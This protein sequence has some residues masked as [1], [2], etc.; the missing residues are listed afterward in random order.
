MSNFDYKNIDEIVKDDFPKRGVTIS[1][2]DLPALQREMVVP[3]FIP[4]SINS[5]S[6]E[7]DFKVELHVFTKNL[8]YIRSVY[9]IDTYYLLPGEIPKL[10]LQVHKDLQGLGLASSEYRVVYNLI[11]NMVGG[12]NSPY[13]LF[14]SEISDDRTELKLSLADPNSQIGRELLANFVLENVKP[15][16]FL[17]PIVLNFGENKV[18]DVIN[19][20]SDGS[21]TSFF[22]KLYEPLPADLDVY[23]VCWAGV[24][25]M[26]P[27]IDTVQLIDETTQ[28]TIPYISGPNFEVD[29]DYWITT[30]TDYKSWSDI[31][32]E[33][34]QTSEQL[35]NKYISS[36]GAPVELNVDYTDFSNFVYYSNARDRVENFIYKMELIEY[37]RSELATLQAVTG[38]VQ[39]NIVKV[40][41]LKDKV[42]SGFD[43]FEKHL[44][45]NTTGS[46]NYTYQATASIVPYPKYEVDVTSS[47]YHIATKE[48]KFKFYSSGSTEV[49]D[50]VD[51]ILDYADDYDAKNYSSLFRAL[52]DHVKE[53]SEND[54]AIMFVN[55]LGQHFDIMYLYTDH[56]LK[57]NLREEHPKDGL[58][59]DLIYDI[60][61]NMGWTLS[62][63]TSAKDLWEYALGISGSTE[64][65]WTGKTT[66][67]RYLTKSYEERTKEVWRRIL[68][69]LPYIYKTKGT[70]RSIKALLAAYGIPSTLLTI[71]EYGGPDNADLGVKPR[72]V[73][74]KHTY[75]LSY[76]SSFPVPTQTQYVRVPWEPVD[77]VSGYQYPDSI[78]FRWKMQTSDVYDYSIGPVQTLLQKN[79][80]SRVDWFVTVHRTGSNV[81]K[82]DLKFH[83]GDGTTY[84]TASIQ[85]EYLFDEVPLNIM[86]QRSSKNDSTA[87]TQEYTLYLKSAKY[88]RIA[89]DRSASIAVS[90][91]LIPNTQ[92]AWVS[93]GTLYIGSGSNPNTSNILS[94]SIF[95]LRYWTQILDESVFENHVL[96]ARAYN[97]NTPTSSYYDLGAQFKFWQPFDAASTSSLSSTH[98]DQTKSSFQTSQKVATLVGFTSHSFESTTETYNMEVATVGNNTPFSEKVRIDSG[99]LLGPLSIDQTSEVSAFD[100][101][102]VDSNRLMVAFS[103][104]SIINEDI[105]EA[106]GNVAIDDYFGEYSNIEADE[107]PRLKWL[108]REYWKKYP[109]KNDFT[110]YIRLISIFDF[111]IFDQIRQALP[112]RANEIVGIVVE[113]NVLERSKVRVTKGISGESPLQVN[114]DTNEISASIAIPSATIT[115]YTSTLRIGFED[116]DSEY[117]ELNAE[118]DVVT[119]LTGEE[120][121]N[122]ASD[123]EVEV[124][125]F[126]ENTQKT[127]NITGSRTPRP[128]VVSSFRPYVGVV[129][130]SAADTVGSYNL[131]NALITTRISTTL[132][133]VN[134]TVFDSADLDTSFTSTYYRYSVRPDAGSTTD[135]GYGAGW[136]TM[137]NESGKATALFSTIQNYRGDTYYRQYKF[138][139]NTSQQIAERAFTSSSFVSA[140][141]LDPNDFTTSIRNVQFEGCKITGPDINVDTRNTPDGKPVVEIYFVNPD[142]VNTDQNMDTSAG[143]NISAI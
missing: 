129:T 20:T 36:S 133:S 66:V 91:S 9:D 35:I 40:S 15:K 21:P 34:V 126:G 93:D 22:V 122:V 41:M 134:N 54:Q 70:A 111:S 97:G 6:G 65:I 37:Y 30:E 45:Y 2:N 23:Y 3:E 46:V 56:L 141:Y 17:P 44:Y 128:S 90:G 131:Y 31:L 52:P 82:G 13:N 102:S 18:L 47:D 139:Y 74:D 25:V 63:G 112:A 99:S 24:R 100:T 84:L 14:I 98:P 5:I 78:E 119:E 28:P 29:Y 77:G 67:D 1:L 57:K 104:Q 83:I 125:P 138:F 32:S 61:K 92:R 7:R 80:G 115:S 73:W 88:G 135:I 140:S 87:A 16:T 8:S 72:A 11:R 68:N 58:S 110:A 62:H 64:P 51:S 114:R 26:K 81:E 121:T 143:G 50:W 33:N 130:S 106:M 123:I 38:S 142:Q 85:N 95:E 94:G 118:T 43:G 107:Y 48:G 103:P 27:Y 10:Q 89:V 136:V 105:Y 79:A 137:S 76:H 60:T 132:D 117:L 109:N 116:D 101:Y 75:Y 71:R 12:E 120:Q 86:I 53:N 49:T 124:Q 4:D 113:P 96:A 39:T 55:M 69:N 108:A 127:L 42:I 19:V 59:Q